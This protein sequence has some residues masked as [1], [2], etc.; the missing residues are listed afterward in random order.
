MRVLV[1][2]DLPGDNLEFEDAIREADQP[3]VEIKRLFGDA[4]KTQLNALIAG[5]DAALRDGEH[6][7]E[8]PATEFDDADLIILDNNLAHLEIVGTRLTAEAVAGY[9]R[10][11][12]SAPYI[13]SI[14]KN[15]DVDF[16]LRYLIGDYATRAD[17]AL[18]THHLRNP[19]LWTRT[20]ADAV[21]GFLPWYW[22]NLLE[23]GADR[24]ITIELVRAGLNQHVGEVFG[25]ADEDFKFLSR[26]ARSLL[27]QAEEERDAELERQ[28]LYGATAT[29]QEVFLASGRSLPNKEERESLYRKLVQ[30]VDGVAAIVARVV[31]A[32]IDLW[33]RRDVL[34]P[35][36]TVV[37][38]PHLLMRLP[39][40]LGDNANEVDHWN[41]AVDAAANDPPFGL[42]EVLF[43]AHL[44]QTQFGQGEWPS[45]PC[46]WWP[47]LRENEA[48]N[49][50][51]SGEQAG[52]WAEVVFCEDRSEFLPSDPNNATPEPVEFVAQFEGSWNRR[53][54]AEIDGIRY[55]PKSRF[56]K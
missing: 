20:R 51:F 1:C 18:N 49:A 17:L 40:L 30:G 43:A 19:A 14:N 39:F 47:T 37:D 12:S 28:E 10:A 23:A 22:P 45:V 27:S 6:A 9:I 36:E 41:R 11:F 31:A 26:Q 5:A 8:L 53:Y 2:D 44:K 48:L 34:G 35:Q 56:A 42:D 54:V 3:T 16:D 32:D 55:A 13:V 7:I 15:P 29:C 46:F 25:L 21:N 50:Y 33:F 24:R 38:I 52:S 4:L